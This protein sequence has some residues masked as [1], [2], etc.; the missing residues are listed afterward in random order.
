MKVTATPL[1]KSTV[2]LEVELPADRLQRSI[3]ESIRRVG[4]R[5]RVA[6]FRP[7]KAPRAM[8]ERVLGVDRDQPDGPDPIYDEA[9]DLLFDATLL[10]ALRE[11]D[12]DPIAIPQPEWLSF[13]EGEGAA[14]RVQL[15]VRPEVKLG[16]YLDYPFRPEVSEVD[17][18]KVTAVVDDLRDQ[19]ASLRPVE[20]RPVQD[21]DWVVIGFEGTRD[22]EPFEGGKAERFP[23]I[24]GQSRLLPGFEEHLVGMAQGEEKDFDLTFPEDYAETTLAGQPVRFHVL[25]RDVREKL[26]PDADDE[27]AGTIGSFAGM[28]ELRADIHERLVAGAKD[29]AR[30]DFA[31]RIVEY[32]SANATVELPDLLVDQEVE[33]MHDELLLRLAEEKIGYPEY[34]EAIKKDDAAIRADLRVTA[35]KRVKTLLVLSKIAETDGIEVEDAAVDA[36]IQ[37]GR[38]RYASDPKLISY[39]ESPRGRANIR[40]T[41]RRARVVESLIDRWLEAHPEFGPLPHMDEVRGRSGEEGGSAAEAAAQALKAEARVAE[42]Q[43]EA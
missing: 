23:L 30:H 20:D 3:D 17:E 31:D 10:E 41:L 2:A 24:V 16:D 15:P 12:L 39:M 11:T 18:E 26:L 1:P 5:T 35:E 19:H 8:L 40:S 36:E 34:L 27:F 25:V 14:Y 7:G 28:A 13:V 32:A 38:Q 4:R 21:G 42:A 6:G 43:E 29:R 37:L 33:I 9:K 22:G